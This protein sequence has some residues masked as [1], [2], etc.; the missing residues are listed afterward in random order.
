MK[1]FFSLIAILALTSTGEV[2]ANNFTLQ[3]S[4]ISGGNTT[5]ST[6]SS[7]SYYN[8]FSQGFSEF[9]S[10][11]NVLEL[12]DNVIDN[13]P[14]YSSRGGSST[15]SSS[16][17]DVIA[18][19][20]ISHDP[21]ILQ[22]NGNKYMLIKENNDKKFDRNDILGIT[23]TKETVFA[24][25]RPLDIDRDNKLTG[26]ELAKSGVRLVKIGQNGKLINDKKQDFQNTKIVYIYMKELRKAYK[27]DGTTGDF[28]MY[29]VLIKNDNGKTNL[30]TGYVTFEKPDELS[31]YF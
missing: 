8:G 13:A 11:K 29:D 28:G 14:A 2:F 9:Y 15:Q 7:K 3:S 24:S 25:L 5:A 31:K 20:G 27:N 4:D 16:R 1:K 18:S 6:P 17:P 22:I 23:D 30:V 21:Y 12:A 19:S 26:E 10:R